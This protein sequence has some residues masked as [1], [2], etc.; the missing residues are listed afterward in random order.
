[1][2]ERA[3]IGG[4]TDPVGD[5]GCRL[6]PFPRWRKLDVLSL[7][8]IVAGHDFNYIIKIPFSVGACLSSA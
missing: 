2:C 8:S 4:F 5:D 6:S 7:G 1:M 3:S